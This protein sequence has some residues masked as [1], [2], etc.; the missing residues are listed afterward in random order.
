MLSKLILQQ[1][2]AARK[3]IARL[4]SRLKYLKGDNLSHA[5]K[6][7]EDERR[8]LS[9]DFDLV[10]NISELIKIIDSVRFNNRSKMTK[11]ALI[12]IWAE[13]AISLPGGPAEDPTFN[14]DNDYKPL[15]GNLLAVLEHEVVEELSK[16][17]RKR[18]SSQDDLTRWALKDAV[19]A[20]YKGLNLP[21]NTK[22]VETIFDDRLVPKL[23]PNFDIIYGM[24]L[25]RL[26]NMTRRD[27]KYT[28][29]PDEYDKAEKDVQLNET[30]MRGSAFE[31]QLDRY[32]EEF[33][34][35]LK[36]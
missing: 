10:D 2:I 16:M 30:G 4:T 22:I 32:R 26:Y 1:K 11:K 24:W 34:K 8:F 27:D 14:P 28:L 25:E 31:K 29:E 5:V 23:A 7:I 13:E 33:M 21:P 20:Y 15:F 18:V 9:C 36:R 6:I 17:E 35:K 19:L 12:E 3:S